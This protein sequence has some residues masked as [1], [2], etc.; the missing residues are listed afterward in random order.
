MRIAVCWIFEVELDVQFLKYRVGKDVDLSA[1]VNF[2]FNQ[3]ICRAYLYLCIY[4]PLIILDST[5]STY[6]SE[7]TSNSL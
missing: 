4:C 5:L 2:E 6:T 7:Y 1:C 3:T